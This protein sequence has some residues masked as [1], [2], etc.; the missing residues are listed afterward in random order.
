ML[1]GKFGSFPPC[2]W[3]EYAMFN[4]IEIEK[5]S[6]FSIAG[7]NVLFKWLKKKSN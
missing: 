6:N 1:K 2:K 5:I 3:Q 4:L 7:V